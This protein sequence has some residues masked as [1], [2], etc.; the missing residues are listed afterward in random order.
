MAKI[1]HCSGSKGKPGSGK[2]TLMRKVVKELSVA[3]GQ[4]KLLHYTVRLLAVLTLEA[5]MTLGASLQPSFSVKGKGNSKQATHPC[6]RSYSSTSFPT[7]RRV[8]T[9][10]SAPHTK[11]TEIMVNLTRLGVWKIGRYYLRD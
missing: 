1:R 4:C 11:I 3:S 7:M 9:P 6:S 2:N 5:K 10:F 8:F